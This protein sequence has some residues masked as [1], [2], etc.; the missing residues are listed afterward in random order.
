[1][2]KLSGVNRRLQHTIKFVKETEFWPETKVSLMI[3][4]E[5]PYRHC[6]KKF[7]QDLRLSAVVS[8]A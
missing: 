1:M 7:V 8:Q 2:K 4:Q 3:V 6:S 5:I